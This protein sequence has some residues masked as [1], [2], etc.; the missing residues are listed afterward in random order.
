[1]FYILR[2]TRQGSLQSPYL[3]NICINDLLNELE[4]SNIGLNI[5]NTMYNCVTYADDITLLSASATGLQTLIDKYVAYSRK[6]RFKCNPR[7]SKCLVIGKYVFNT[8][9][10]WYIGKDQPLENLKCLE[11]LGISFN[12]DGM[13][14][15]HVNTRISNCK[16]HKAFYGLRDAGMAYPGAH[17][18]IKKYLW[19]NYLL[20]NFYYMEWNIL[21]YLKMN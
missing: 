1:M 11:I 18:S 6:W 19:N 8:E 10:V 3:F 12:S 7:K 2:G 16:C 9:P 20:T 17:A 21:I 15:D 13:S 4:S 5:G 14:S